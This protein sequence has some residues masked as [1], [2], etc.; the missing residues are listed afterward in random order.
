[1]PY[2]ELVMSKIEE[3]LT[4]GEA[5]GELGVTY[6]TVRRWRLAGKLRYYKIGGRYFYSPT[7]IQ[8]FILASERGNSIEFKG[9]REKG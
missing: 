6:W 3:M 9:S 4:E 8:Q 2:K 5:A 7:Q 1:M